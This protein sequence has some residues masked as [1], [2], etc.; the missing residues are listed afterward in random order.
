MQFWCWYLTFWLRWPDLPY[1]Q[2]RADGETEVLVVERPHGL[3]LRVR[4]SASGRGRRIDHRGIRTFASHLFCQGSLLPSH[5]ARKLR[6]YPNCQFYFAGG[7]EGSGV[8]TFG[9]N[10]NC[11]GTG[12]TTW[13]ARSKALTPDEQA[14]ASLDVRATGMGQVTGLEARSQLT[15]DD[16]EAW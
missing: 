3:T 4:L 5:T 2:G 13:R 12:W 9:V 14:D 16:D 7:P 15:S 1:G 8:V 6:R 11:D 10:A